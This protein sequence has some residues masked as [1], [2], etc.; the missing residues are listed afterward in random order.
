MHLDEGE[1]LEVERIHI[2]KAVDMIM[3]G[4]IPDGKTQALVMRVAEMLRRGEIKK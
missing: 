1:F 3:N 4:E 2:D